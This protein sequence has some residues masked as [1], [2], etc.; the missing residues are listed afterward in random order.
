M[1]IVALIGILG[2]GAWLLAPNVANQIDQLM[3]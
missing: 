1:V 3:E 2:P